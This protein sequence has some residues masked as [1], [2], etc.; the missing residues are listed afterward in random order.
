MSGKEGMKQ[1]PKELNLGAVWM[2]FEGGMTRAEIIE[3]FAQAGVRR[4]NFNKKMLNDRYFA[5]QWA[6]SR[7]IGATHPLFSLNR[8][9][10][11]VSPGA[12]HYFPGFF[13]PFTTATYI[14]LRI[15]R[16]INNT[17]NISGSQI[18]I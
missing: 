16:K 2:F 10:L 7:P 4:I 6:D 18:P 12:V 1:Y 15:P 5:R 11:Y 17:P 3:A 14:K 13:K 8:G 9:F